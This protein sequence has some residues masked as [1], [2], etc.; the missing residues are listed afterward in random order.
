MSTTIRQA[1]IAH[2]MMSRYHVPMTRE[3]TLVTYDT[4]ALAKKLTHWGEYLNEFALPAWNDIPDFGL[5]MEQV[6]ALVNRYLD[7][8]PPDIKGEGV[9]T[10]ATINNYVRK[11]IMPEPR[12]KRYYRTHL[13]YL[14]IICALKQSMSIAMLHRLLPPSMNAAELEP[15]Y[16]AFVQ[17]HHSACLYFVR[18]GREAVRDILEAQPNAPLPPGRVKELIV[19]SALTGGFARLLAEKLMALDGGVANETLLEVPGVSDATENTSVSAP[20]SPPTT[21]NTSVS[22]QFSPHTT[23]NASVSAPTSPKTSPSLATASS[24]PAPHTLSAAP[25]SLA[26]SAL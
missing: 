18:E 14:I 3:G 7:F 20:F 1:H 12:K 8:L 4:A 23:E 15:A 25:A 11:N 22:A 9:V 24:A 16:T 2:K 17:R 10:A 21:E 26:P 5:Y 19:S 13:A 6:V